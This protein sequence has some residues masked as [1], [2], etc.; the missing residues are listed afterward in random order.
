MKKT[1]LCLLLVCVMAL[2]GI[3]VYA[4]EMTDEDGVATLL[5]LLQENR[6]KKIDVILESVQFGESMNEVNVDDPILMV[7]A[8][9][10]PHVL[11]GRPPAEVVEYLESL[12]KNTYTFVLLSETPVVL[13]LYSDQTVI[14][15]AKAGYYAGMAFVG[16]IQTGLVCQTF[17]GKECNVLDVYVIN[18]STFG[19]AIVYETD[20][21][22]YVRFYEPFSTEDTQPLELSWEEY[23][24]YAF[25]WHSERV[26]HASKYV[27]GGT[28]SFT[29][30]VE[31]YKAQKEAER[32][33]ELE[34]ARQKTI[35]YISI[36]AGATVLCAATATTLLLR[37]RKKHQ[38]TE[39]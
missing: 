36:G 25:A 17:V 2:S 18:S 30:F 33:A 16:E 10:T 32:Q 22:I 35:L 1:L 20:R 37:R 38:T 19:A 7:Y 11:D 27:G 31:K 34:A 14:N 21:G 9:Y 26:I 6:T 15:V 5:D 8:E 24:E 39:E 23:S 29:D 13:N 3:S 28:S 4:D 12:D